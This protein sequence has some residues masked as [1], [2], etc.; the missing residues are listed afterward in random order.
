MMVQCKMDLN[1]TQKYLSM[2]FVH[3]PC[4]APYMTLLGCLHHS[5]EH[6]M[7]ETRFAVPGLSSS[8]WVHPEWWQ[9]IQL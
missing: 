6:S 7:L 3:V 1:L 2:C 8:W 5:L 9:K 4:I